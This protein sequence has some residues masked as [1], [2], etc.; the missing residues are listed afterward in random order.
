MLLLAVLTAL[1]AQPVAPD[2]PA[3][4][5]AE[6]HRI[7]TEMKSYAKE[8]K[9]AGVEREYRRLLTLGVAV[10]PDLHVLAA[11]GARDR[12]DSLTAM[13][14]L[15]RVPKGSRAG[16]EVEAFEQNLIGNYCYLRVSLQ[17][18]AKVEAPSFFARD[19]ATAAQR[20]IEVV[21]ASGV[22]VGL[23]PAGEYRFDGETVSLQGGAAKS[24]PEAPPTSP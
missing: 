24:V 19:E 6:A 23:V 11:M 21:A 9:P 15:S 20:M 3:A 13:A 12:G 7:A 5:A 22:F 8:G 10:D 1:A 2:D 18:G 14:R 17:P 4:I 16:A